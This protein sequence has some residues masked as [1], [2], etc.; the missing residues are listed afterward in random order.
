MAQ[1][2]TMQFPTSGWVG[3]AP[4]VI[5]AGELIGANM[6]ST[7]DQAIVMSVPATRYVVEA[8]VVS[9]ASV[10][11]DTAAGGIYSVASKGGV[12]LVAA[13]QVYSTL[14]AAAVNAAGSAL[15]LT[16]DTPATT[17]MFDLSTLYFSLTT[18]Q[19]AAATADIRVYVR[20]LYA[21]PGAG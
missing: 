13:A 11:L 2:S 19:G 3:D 6:N 10:S 17:G 16:L 21:P 9:N 4:G 8:I 5:L 7:A 15:F 18:A 1:G 20:P 14:T 12:T